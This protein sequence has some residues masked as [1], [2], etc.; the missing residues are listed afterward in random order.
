MPGIDTYK[1]KIDKYI[2]DR[3]GETKPPETGKG[4]LSPKE[5]KQAGAPKQKDTIE[6]VSEFVYALRQKRKEI[7]SNRSKK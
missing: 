5:I 6:Y 2:K 1:K 7:V 4:L 3:E